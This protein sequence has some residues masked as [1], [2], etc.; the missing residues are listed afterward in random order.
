MF[1]LEERVQA[2][3]TPHPG[4]ELTKTTKEAGHANAGITDGNTT[5]LE[6]VQREHEDCTS[7]GEKT[8]EEV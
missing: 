1:L 3:H 7:S 6:V 2:T 5:D 4:D 8:A